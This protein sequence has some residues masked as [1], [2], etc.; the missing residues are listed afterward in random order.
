MIL[1]ERLNLI[2]VLQLY[3]MF[4]FSPHDDVY[5]GVDIYAKFLQHQQVGF[6]F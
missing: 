6:F 3:T 2:F 1:A 4:L 5:T